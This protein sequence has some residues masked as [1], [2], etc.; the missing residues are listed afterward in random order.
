M[1]QTEELSRFELSRPQYSIYSCLCYFH[2]F[3]YPLK[4]SEI[5]EFSDIS[6]NNRQTQEYLDELSDMGLVFCKDGYYYTEADFSH[7]IKRRHSSE[8]RFL[9]KQKTIRRYAKFV[10]RFPFVEAVAISGSC[11]KG[12]LDEDGDVDYFI[13]TAPGRLWMCRSMLILFKKVFLLNS[14]KYFCLNYFVDSDTLEIPDHNIFVASEIKTL[15]PVNNKELFER[16]QS[17]NQ[18]TNS[19]LPNKKELN[20]SFFN[21]VNPKKYLFGFMQFM[22]DNRL[23]ATIDEWCFRK[24]FRIWKKRF[25]GLNEN[26]FDLNF[27]SRKTVSKHHPRGFQKKVLFELEK[28]LGKIRVMA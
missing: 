7:L 11:S 10:S 24:T 16:F 6:L 1:L 8:K 25:S 18:W 14:K 13:I 26:D 2:I 5:I 4:V 20:F 21:Q 12:L 22:L 9:Q 28:S 3:K 17:A 19:F 27:R 15:L 23:G